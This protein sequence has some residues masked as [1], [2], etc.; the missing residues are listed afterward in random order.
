MAVEQLL[1][2]V[3]LGGDVRALAELEH[4]L[5]D[6]RAYHARRRPR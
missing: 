1:R 5:E 3:R 6:G 2:V 4:G